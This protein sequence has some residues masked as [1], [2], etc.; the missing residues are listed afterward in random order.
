MERVAQVAADF[1]AGRHNPFA[2]VDLAGLSPEAR[3]KANEWQ[4]ERG[5]TPVE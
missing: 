3:A 4:R 1:E 2:I 5:F